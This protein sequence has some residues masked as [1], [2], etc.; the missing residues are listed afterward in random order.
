M[1]LCDVH[2][3]VRGAPSETL[4]LSPSSYA[5]SFTAIRPKQTFLLLILIGIFFGTKKMVSVRELL[6]V[7]FY[8]RDLKVVL[9]LPQSRSVD[10]SFAKKRSLLRTTTVRSR[11]YLNHFYD[12]V[13]FE[14]QGGSSCMRGSKNN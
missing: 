8:L 2:A 9:L 14:C 7:F 3:I 6:A 11:V 5:C 1:E 13:L 10:E 12:Y 4:G